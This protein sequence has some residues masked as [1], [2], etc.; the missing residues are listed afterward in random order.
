MARRRPRR[1]ILIGIAGA[2]DDERD[3]VGSALAFS[4]VAVDGIGVGAGAGFEGPSRLGFPQWPGSADTGGGRVEDDLP[5]VLPEGPDGGLLLT[6]CAASGSA[7]QARERLARHPDARAEDMEGFSVA[8]A[9]A[10]ADVPVTIV[11][12]ISNRVGEIATLRAGAF[13]RRW[14]PRAACC[15]RSWTNEAT[16]TRDL[17]LPERHVRVPCPARPSGGRRGRRARRGAH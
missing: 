15:S 17:H 6:T 8:M 12:G 1:A 14:P 10:L 11:R 2:F 13:P 7:A 4:R 3:P 5:L 16:P 9:G